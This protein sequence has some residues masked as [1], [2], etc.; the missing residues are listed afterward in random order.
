M[1]GQ[2]ATFTITRASDTGYFTLTGQDALK[3][4]SELI[5]SST[6]TLT[7]QDATLTAHIYRRWDIPD[8]NPAT[9]TETVT[10]ANTAI[11]VG[12]ED[13]DTVSELLNE[14]A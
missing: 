11:L 1:T 10:N 5:P 3:G 2:D 14:A 12:V 6:F 7:G 4:I 9:A 13:E 8:S